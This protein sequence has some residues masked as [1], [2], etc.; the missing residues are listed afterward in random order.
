MAK[1][2]REGKT[3]DKEELW[4][5]ALDKTKAYLLALDGAPAAE[6]WDDEPVGVM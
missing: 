5:D 2:K 6:N 3:I 1:A 4:Q